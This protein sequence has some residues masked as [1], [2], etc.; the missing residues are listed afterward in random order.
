MSFHFVS[1][2]QPPITETL[3]PISRNI[4]FPLSS[5]EKDSPKQYFQI[6]EI[7]LLLKVLNTQLYSTA[8]GT[9]NMK[10]YFICMIKQKKRNYSNH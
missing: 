4:M 3:V 5:Q 1:A 8:S 6:K 2:G 9:L 7:T 10:V